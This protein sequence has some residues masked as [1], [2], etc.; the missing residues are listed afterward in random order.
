MSQSEDSTDSTVTVHNGRTIDIMSLAA[1]EEEESEE[2]L[3]IGNVDGAVLLREEI[4]LMIQRGS[5]VLDCMNEM[6]AM[7]LQLHRTMKND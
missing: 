5:E 4:D 6:M 1:E 3:H 7:L 2:D